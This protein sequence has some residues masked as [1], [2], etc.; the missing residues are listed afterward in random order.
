MQG[1]QHQAVAAECDDDVGLR[2]IGIAVAFLKP[3]VGLTRF[4]RMACDK[5]DML[6]SRAHK[7]T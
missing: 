2:G 1:L 5:G 7:G 6:K 3:A 4:R